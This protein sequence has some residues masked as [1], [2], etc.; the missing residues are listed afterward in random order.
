MVSGFFGK[1]VRLTGMSVLLSLCLAGIRYDSHFLRTKGEVVIENQKEIVSALRQG[2]RNHAKKISITFSTKRDV[3][4]QTGSL[5]KMWM[6]EALQET[7]D[8]C[9]GDY[10]R[11]QYGGYQ[12]SMTQQETENGYDYQIQIIPDYYT[13]LIQE[14]QVDVWVAE[15]LSSLQIGEET[16]EIQKIKK[17]YRYVYEHV[18]YDEVHKNKK[19]KHMKTTA[20]AAI[21]YHAAVCQGYA[22]LI[23]RLLREAGIRTRIITGEAVLLSG[24]KERHAWNIVEYKG[25]FYNMD[26]TWDRA[27]GTEDCFMKA[28]N[29][30]PDHLRD[31]GYQTEVFGSEYPMAGKSLS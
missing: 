18:A 25:L 15:I 19:Q 11:F 2:L 6:E 29:D 9:E 28:D 20:Y 14:E 13:Y 31:A 30:F 7:E 10:I 1:L 4:G 8:P 16:E 22:V 26:V 23:Y 5:T 12:T 17:I 3:S 27:T 21:K 24:K